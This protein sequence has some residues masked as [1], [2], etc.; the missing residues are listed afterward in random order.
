M[1]LRKPTEKKLNNNAYRCM[2]MA[3]D[4]ERFREL[5]AYIIHTTIMA[6]VKQ[7]GELLRDYYTPETIPD[8]GELDELE[9]FVK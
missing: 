3:W 9:T 1:K 6:L 8:L 7:V 2:L 5:Q 4:F